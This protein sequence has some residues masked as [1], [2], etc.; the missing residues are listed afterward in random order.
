[1]KAR[2]RTLTLAVSITLGGAVLLPPSHP[3]R[4]SVAYGAPVDTPS[5]SALG[6]SSARSARITVTA[7]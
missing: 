3:A 6:E 1:M 7:R 5:T 4:A 2:Q